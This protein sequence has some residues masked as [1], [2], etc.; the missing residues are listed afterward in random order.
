MNTEE[1]EQFINELNKEIV[2]THTITASRLLKMGKIGVNAFTLYNFYCWVASWQMTNRVKANDKFC[3]KGLHW[4]RDKFRLAKNLLIKEKI[5][6]VKN[7]RN[8][9]GQ[10][11]AHYIHIH[12][13]NGFTRSPEIHSMVKPQGGKQ[14]TNTTSIDKKGNAIDKNKY[15]TTS[16]EVGKIHTSPESGEVKEISKEVGKTRSSYVNEDINYLIEKFHEITDLKKLDGSIRQNRRYCWLLLKKVGGKK[17]NVEN[18]IKL[19]VK[20]PFHRA[21]LT[22]FK[23][24]YY[25]AVKILNQI[26]V[27]KET[28]RAIEIKIKK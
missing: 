18:L 19:A 4:G 24:L 15:T 23:Y 26:K 2:L 16:K 3:M 6:E 12:F 28:P 8:E 7:R 21:N 11:V 25:N 17:E 5:I 14:P 22:S 13:L 27:A 9:K 1:K 20:D 10:I